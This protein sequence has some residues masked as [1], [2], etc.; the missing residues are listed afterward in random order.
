MKFKEFLLEYKGEHEAPTKEGS[1]SLDD[2]TAEGIYP[3][4]VYTRGREYAH[5]DTDLECLSI[6]MACKGKPNKSVRIYRAVPLGDKKATEKELATREKQKAACLR[7]GTVPSDYNGKKSDFYNFVS[8]EI[9]K[10]EKKLEDM[11]DDDKIKINAGDW[12]TLSRAYAVEHGKDHLNGKYKI[13]SKAVKA[14][15]LHTDGNSL[16]EWG[17]NP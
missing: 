15:E 8:D 11:A 1:A 14:K 7:R 17:W 5:G 4:D 16:S 10:L 6:A 12:V 2:L 9:E 3:D 13:L